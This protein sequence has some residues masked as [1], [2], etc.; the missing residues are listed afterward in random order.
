MWFL[1]MITT[2]ANIEEAN[3]NAGLWSY[4]TLEGCIS[5]LKNISYNEASNWGSTVEWEGPYTVHTK[6]NTLEYTLQCV[7]T[8]GHNN[9]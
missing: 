7:Q 9:K 2:L 5:T 8:I 1:I 3:P 6:N 4:S